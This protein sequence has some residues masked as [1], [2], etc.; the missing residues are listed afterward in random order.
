MLPVELSHDTYSLVPEQKRP[1]LICRMQINHSGEITAYEFAEGQIRSQHKLSYQAVHDAVNGIKSLSEHK[2]TPHEN[3]EAML[4]ELQAFAQTRAQ[5]RQQHA[6]V[7]EDRAD[8]FFILNEQKKIDHVDKRERNSAHRMI[9]EAMLA[10]NICAGELFLQHPGYGIFSSH[11]G[12]R[13]ERLADA[14][15]LIEEDRPELTPGNL[16]DLSNFQRIF[17]ELRLN[18]EQHPAS[19][20]LQSLLQ[21]MLQAGTLSFDPIGHYG[22]GFKA[23]A[24]VTSPI[25]RYQDFYN[26]L[27]IKC[28]LRGAAAI[29]LPELSKT[30]LIE[31]LQNQITLGRQACRYTEGWLGA[32]F[33]AQQIGS[34]HL[35]SIALVNSQ[36]LGIKLDDLGL[37]GYALLVPKDSTIK[38][39]FDS[40]R[41]S[42]TIEG[43]SY[44]LD[45]KAYVLIKDVDVD[46]RKI[47]LEL[48]S[49]ETAERLMAWF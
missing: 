46:K 47:S 17:K 13:P 37:E 1:A 4:K 35:G 9:E 6:L 25:R 24:M 31:Q 28:I 45:D 36:G 44:R 12:F 11:I 30:Q 5:Y 7:M 19:A 23:Y 16:A 2:I 8:Y 27:A 32:Q 21:R 39:Q 26:H 34:V 49:A 43:N 29:E 42:L 48:V 10:T 15:A 3:L 41:L 33:L 38:A 18:P 14:A 20:P 22:L 40:R